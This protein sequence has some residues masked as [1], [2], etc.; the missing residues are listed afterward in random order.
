MSN[1]AGNETIIHELKFSF[2]AISFSRWNW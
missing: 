1:F 2:Q